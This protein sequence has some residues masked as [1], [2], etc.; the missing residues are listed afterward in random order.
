MVAASVLPVSI[1]KNKL[2]FLFGKENEFE[3]SSKGFSDFGGSVESGETVMDTAYREGSEELIGF[4][5]SPPQLKK[6]IKNSGGTYKIKY[7][8]PSQP[9]KN[10][11]SYLNIYHVNIFFMEY[12]ANLPIYYNQHYQYLWNHH[13]MNK[14]K[15]NETRL[16]EKQEIKWF[17]IDEIKTKKHL[18]RCFYKNILNEIISQKYDIYKFIKKC[19]KYI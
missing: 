7:L 10:D 11:T 5:G 19:E 18:F 14:R 17:S 9:N 12:D 16:F 4:L 2:Y 8:L 13:K 6:R 3:D 15:L 1:Y